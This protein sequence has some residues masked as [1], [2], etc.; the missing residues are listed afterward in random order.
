M[1]NAEALNVMTRLNARNEGFSPSER[2]IAAEIMASPSQVALYSSQVLAQKCNVSQSTIVKF[3]QTL[4]YKG[5]P[6]LKLALSA[7]LAHGEGRQQVHRNISSDD[8]M[9]A[10]A[11]KLYES[12]VAALS[13]T[14]RLSNSDDIAG[15]VDLLFKAQRII[16]FGVGGS[17]LVA[18]DLSG[19]LTKFGKAVLFSGDSHIQLANLASLTSDDLVIAISYS[20]RAKEVT[21]AIEHATKLDVPIIA[22]F[23]YGSKP[24]TIENGIKLTCVAD[25]NLVRSASIATRT[26]QL[27]V[28]DLLFVALS[29]RFENVGERISASQKIVK[30][31]F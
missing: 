1:T 25:E 23:G 29:Q 26:A 28:T 12:K 19:K 31:L 13:E 11:Q 2:R 5:Y 14:M 30:D 16:I 22:L 3:C 4:G 10:V 20:G 17:S 18:Q 8:P 27:A 24:T 21:V 6:A 7:E 15:A 9:G